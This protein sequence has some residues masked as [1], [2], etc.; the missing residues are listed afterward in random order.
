M[1][2]GRKTY[3]GQQ[4]LPAEAG[5]RP[6]AS[7]PRFQSAAPRSNPLANPESTPATDQTPRLAH[8]PPSHCCLPHPHRQT[9]AYNTPMSNLNL[10][11]WRL[12]GFSAL[13]IIG[14]SV[15]LAAFSFADYT[16]A[17]Q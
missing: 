5:N 10:I 13:W 1:P 4:A 2:R 15:L 17:Q 16:A 6:Q 11:D 9:P 3:S 8:P 7:Q 14:L 12:V